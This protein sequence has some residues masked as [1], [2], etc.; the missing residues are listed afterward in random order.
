MSLV[1]HLSGLYF[2]PDFPPSEQSPEELA[3]ALWEDIVSA[4]DRSEAPEI[5]A[6]IVTGDL[7]QAGITSHF[8]KARRFFVSLSNQ[9]IS[10]AKFV[11]VPGASD[12]SVSEIAKQRN[13]LELEELESQ[14]DLERAIDQYK[15]S[16][17]DAFTRDFF[18]DI[19]HMRTP[20]SAVGGVPSSLSW[21]RSGIYRLDL[22][23]YLFE[24]AAIDSCEQ[25]IDPT[26]VTGTV[27][28]AI[29]EALQSCWQYSRAH[30]KKPVLR[31]IALYHNPASTRVGGSLDALS[32]GETTIEAVARDCDVDMVFFGQAGAIDQL[33]GWL[34]KS[35][36][37][38]THLLVAGSYGALDGNERS[39]QLL[40]TAK[41]ETRRLELRRFAYNPRS[42]ASGRIQMGAYLP[43]PEGVGGCSP[44]R[45]G[46]GDDDRP[47]HTQRHSPPRFVKAYRKHYLAK[48]KGWL[49]GARPT[50]AAHLEQMYLPLR[51]GTNLR[52]PGQ[53]TEPREILQNRCNMLIRADAGSG[54]TTW[55]RWTFRR[56]LESQA[57]PVLIELRTITEWIDTPPETAEL[58]IENL[59]SEQFTQLS[60]NRLSQDQLRAAL[61]GGGGL[62]P[63]ADARWLGRAGTA[64]ETLS[65][66][67]R[68]VL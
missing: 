35:G 66:V 11:F 56:L 60:E 2:G 36:D 17:F 55:M 33:N 65:R 22:G 44:L 43:K 20:L 49:F 6:V 61:R 28:A 40:S 59:I 32:S 64:W 12:V 68:C 51:L 10:R 47:S 67:A 8:T 19:D 27:S 31:A 58:S 25:V 5:T 15:L 29:G 50:D 52:S 42:R 16:A 23:D 9:G 4:Q 14:A 62:V 45:V 53:L 63:G 34:W 1:L 3:I 21:A 30:S 7:T 39:F 38:Y 48:Q 18:Q 13:R 46:L 54:K 24:L 41:P 37:G 26:I 57:L